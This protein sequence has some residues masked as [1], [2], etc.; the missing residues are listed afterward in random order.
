MIRSSDLIDREDVYIPK[1]Y[2]TRPERQN[3]DLTENTFVSESEFGQLVNRGQIDIFWKRNLDDKREVKYGFECS[4]LEAKLALYSGNNALFRQRNQIFSP[5][6]LGSM[7]FV[8]VYA[9]EELRS[10]RLQRRS[11]DLAVSKPKEYERR[12]IDSQKVDSRFDDYLRAISSAS[13]PTE[14]DVAH[15]RIFNDK[16]H[17]LVSGDALLHFL[18]G[19]VQIQSGKCYMGQHQLRKGAMRLIRTDSCPFLD[20]DSF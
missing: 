1:R 4:S 9:N 14:D 10:E 5:E 6:Q 12:L 15:F 8:C 3:D 17:E 11:L 7:L 16:D 18:R 13:E 19:I 2:T 20:I